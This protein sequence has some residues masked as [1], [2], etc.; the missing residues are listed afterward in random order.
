MI[1]FSENDPNDLRETLAE[2]CHYQW[3]NWM[4]K[5]F[6]KGHFNDN[7]SWVMP[8]DVVQEIYGILIAQYSQ[9]PEQNRDYV[10]QQ[11]DEIIKVMGVFD[12]N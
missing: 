10:R 4:K 9:L 11:A 7:G 1:M 5:M 8:H 3:S 2:L 6:L 12:D